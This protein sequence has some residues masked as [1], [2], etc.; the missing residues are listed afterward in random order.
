MMYTSRL[1]IQNVILIMIFELIK[2][3]GEKT[4]ITFS[5]KYKMKFRYVPILC[6]Y[7]KYI[8]YI[9]IQLSQPGVIGKLQA[10]N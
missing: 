5:Y 4:L 8:T 2:N 1:I 6:Y 7:P 10:K 9:K 3:A